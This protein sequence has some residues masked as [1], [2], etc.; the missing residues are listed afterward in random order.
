MNQARKKILF[1]LP[2]LLKPLYY[3]T[4]RRLLG[5]LK[6]FNYGKDFISIEAAITCR[7]SLLRPAG[8]C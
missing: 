2:V 5:I 6:Y 4:Q 1:H 7:F 8:L 3:G